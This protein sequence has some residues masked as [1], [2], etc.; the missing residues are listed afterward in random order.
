MYINYQIEL[1]FP[2]KPKTD[3]VI[4]IDGEYFIKFGVSKV[5]GIYKLTNVLKNDWKGYLGNLTHEEWKA[6]REAGRL[7]DAKESDITFKYKTWTDVY[8]EFLDIYDHVLSV[9]KDHDEAHEIIQHH[10]DA[11]YEKHAGD[12]IWD[13]AYERWYDTD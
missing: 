12:P 6:L 13:S 10:V 3:R 7:V 4:V 11:L 5:I 8:M 1:K 9:T 2:K